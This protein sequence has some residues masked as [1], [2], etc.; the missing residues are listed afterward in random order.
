MASNVHTFGKV[1]LATTVGVGLSLGILEIAIPAGIIAGFASVRIVQSLNA[2]NNSYTIDEAI[3]RSN[4]A[5]C[6]GRSIPFL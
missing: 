1:A 6:E 2:D 4:D 3:S 5:S